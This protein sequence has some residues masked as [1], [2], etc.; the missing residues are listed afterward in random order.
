MAEKE[1]RRRPARTHEGFRELFEG[2]GVQ[3]NLQRESTDNP[4]SMITNLIKLFRQHN[5]DVVV[6]GTG[7]SPKPLEGDMDTLVCNAHVLLACIRYMF[8]RIFYTFR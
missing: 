7:T 2:R 5:N 6:H 4:R 1:E 3:A 8:R